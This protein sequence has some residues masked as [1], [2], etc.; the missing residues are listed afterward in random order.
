MKVSILGGGAFGS[1]LAIHL[2]KK[3]ANITVWEFFD[4]IATKLQIERKSDALPGM[5][6]PENVKFTSNIK[7]SIEFAELIVVAV[8]SEKI[9][10]TFNSVKDLIKDQK[11]VVCSKGFTA[12]HKLLT[13]AISDI[14][15]DKE[16]YYLSGPT[17]ALELAKGNLAGM[18]LAGPDFHEEIVELF[19]SDYL[20]IEFSKDQIGCQVG[21]ALKNVINI[22]VGITE[23]LE[24]GE[25]TKA[26]IFTKGL[27]EIANIG[28]AMGAQRETF[29]GLT[30]MGDLTL[31]SRN[32]NVGIKIGKGQTVE[33]IQAEIGQTLEG[34]KA[35][36]HAKALKESLNVH[37]PMIDALN[38]IVYSKADI[39]KTIKAL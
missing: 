36:E 6:L 12:D 32:R 15:Q 19:K 30:C 17:I 8:P 29:Y 1:A 7:E 18:V 4:H 25:D 33:Q 10:E 20:R 3:N 21:A 31:N 27:E 11:I 28:V 34:L 35:L 5:T 23:G 39:A 14:L 38:E 16:I 24:L 9:E 13:V 37:A 22:L 2:S 26:Y